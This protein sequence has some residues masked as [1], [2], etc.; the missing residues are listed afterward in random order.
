M[1]RQTARG[2]TW[3]SAVSRK[4]RTQKRV[5][6]PAGS[7]AKSRGT[8]PVRRAP[9]KKAAT[10]ARAVVRKALSGTMPSVPVVSPFHDEE[11]KHC[12]RPE[13][14]TSRMGTTRM[15]AGRDNR[16]SVSMLARFLLNSGTLR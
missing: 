13:S 2:R 1:A 16:G 7:R 10:P 12:R 9:P 11:M 4:R 8:R 15:R 14:A 6:K 3:A 5:M